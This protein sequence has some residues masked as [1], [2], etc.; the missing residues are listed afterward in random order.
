MPSQLNQK[1]LALEAARLMVNRIET[2]YLHAKERAIL[3][4]G[5]PYNTPY[6]TNRQIKEFIRQLTRNLPSNSAV[7]TEED[8]SGPNDSRLS[9][10]WTSSTSTPIAAAPTGRPV[11]VSFQDVAIE[12]PKRGRVPAFRAADLVI[13]RSGASSCE[14]SVP[15]LNQVR[16]Y[17]ALLVKTLA[18]MACAMFA[19]LVSPKFTENTPRAVASVTAL[20]G[21]APPVLD[22]SWLQ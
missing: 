4:L 11:A 8:T 7:V 20:V 6:P 9:V 17:T 14:P 13:C 21:S 5:L 12:Y 3:M 15:S 22:P 1:R 19:T 18:G 16:R 10:T 2:E